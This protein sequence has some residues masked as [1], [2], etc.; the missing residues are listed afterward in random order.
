MEWGLEWGPQERNCPCGGCLDTHFREDAVIGHEKQ[1]LTI[2]DYR[3]PDQIHCKGEEDKPVSGVA[4]TAGG[5]QGHALWW[6]SGEVDGLGVR[7]LR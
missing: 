2:S 6:T 3:G 1:A 7:E 5:R 4:M